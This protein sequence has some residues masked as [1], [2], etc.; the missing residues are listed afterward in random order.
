MPTLTAK[1]L[2]IE[3]LAKKTYLNLDQRQELT[4]S[5]EA[6]STMLEETRMGRVDGD[7]EALEKQGHRERQM[8]LNGAPPELDTVSKNRLYRIVKDLE[9]KFTGG[10]PTYEQMQIPSP[11]HIDWHIAWERQHKKDVLAWKTGLMMLSPD[12]TEPNFRNIARLRQNK[13]AGTDPRKYWQ[14]FEAIKFEEHEQEIIDDLIATMDD[15]A[16]TLFLQLKAAGWAKVNILKHLGWSKE[17]YAAAEFRFEQA[18]SQLKGGDLPSQPISEPISE[19]EE[20]EELEEVVKPEKGWP[21]PLIVATGSSVNKFVLQSGV[22]DK[23]TSR[24]YNTCKTG[25]WKPKD[26]KIIE[27]HLA[28]LN[29]KHQAVAE[30]LTDDVIEPEYTNVTE[31]AE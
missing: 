18:I 5:I 30:P 16:Y 8:L 7:A 4:R 20:L 22:C 13:A 17:L 21:I 23:N 29:A 2:S 19:P 25:K 12:N 26:K 31:P 10:L 14:G 28:K 24:F 11:N 1:D 3:S 9:D 6:T 15:G 27:V